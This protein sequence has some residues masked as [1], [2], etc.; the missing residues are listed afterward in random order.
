MVVVVI[1]GLLA[2]LILPNVLG[3]QDQALMIKARADVKAIASQLTLYKLDNFTYPT[4][5]SGLQA[6]LSNVENKPNWRGY[7]NKPIKDPWGNEY[8]Y[9]S[10][11][12]NSKDFDVWSFGA[13]GK[14]GGEGS[15]ADIGNWE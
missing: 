10:P 12:E 9:R 6:L 7:I 15:N 2:T 5:S 14:L 4:T 11:G 8:Q 1:I 13:D 3:R